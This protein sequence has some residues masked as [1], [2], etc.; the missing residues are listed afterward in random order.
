[1]SLAVFQ[2]WRDKVHSTKILPYLFGSVLYFDLVPGIWV[3][4]GVLVHYG[5]GT[6]ENGVIFF[7]LILQIY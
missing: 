3:V 2:S 6:R 5:Q 1:M 7:F 4:S